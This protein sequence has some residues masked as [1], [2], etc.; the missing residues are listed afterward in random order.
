MA[1]KT[2]AKKEVKASP[3]RT[4]VN[5]LH[6]THAA[7]PPRPQV[8]MFKLFGVDD[9]YGNIETPEDYQKK[10]EAMTITDLHEH[11]HIKGIVPL[12]ARDKLVA[13]LVKKYRMAKAAQMPERVY[14][15]PVNPNLA[16]FHRKLCSD[17]LG[18]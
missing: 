15:T 3:K 12:D 14:S 9:G 11:A 2:N 18:F 6:Q 16:D 5:E 13:S 7:L 1:K 8:N 4:A 10:L 17:T